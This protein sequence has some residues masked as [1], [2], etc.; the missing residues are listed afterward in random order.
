MLQPTR[1][2]KGR[3]SPRPRRPAKKHS[4]VASP[5]EQTCKVLIKKEPSGE[6]PRM[7]MTKMLNPIAVNARTCNLRGTGEAP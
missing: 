5:Q 3:L 2:Q 4:A 7:R 1:T 6:V